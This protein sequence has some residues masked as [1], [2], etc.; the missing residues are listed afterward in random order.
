MSDQVPTPQNTEEVD[1]GQLF[2]AIGKL[3][4]KVYVFV[5]SIFKSIF[6]VIIYTLKAFID[7]WKILVASLL[8]AFIAGKFLE[9]TKPTI[10][11]SN[12]L[13]QP[14]FDSKYDLI[15]KIG[16]YNALIA[17]R[18]YKTLS[19]IFT[20]SEDD[21]KKINFFDIKPGPETENQKLVQYNKYLKSV[22]S[23]LVID[24]NIN[25]ENYIENRSIYS[26]NL[27]EITVQSLK[28][29]IFPYLEDGLNKSFKNSYSKSKRDKRDTIIK[30]KRES[31]EKDMEEVKRLQKIY[32]DV[33]EDDTKSNTKPGI[34]IGKSGISLSSDK[35]ETR[36][37]ELL[38]REIAIRNQL[39]E[40]DEEQIEENTFFDVISGFQAIGTP[41]SSFFDR[42]SI[43]LPILTFLLLCMFYVARKVIIYVNNYEE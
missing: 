32:I 36:E 9:R 22:D 4:N 37:F 19:E 7:N 15:G 33:I 43:I 28:K 12:M 42:Y 1:L 13:V 18:D 25:Y 23:S 11:A 38:N 35:P 8:I 27:F 26:G 2:N 41:T 16:Y 14:N 20:L 21:V 39:R 29:D 10:Y 34:E 24:Q 3:F 5:A 40:L 17:S 31:L 6:S 30:Y